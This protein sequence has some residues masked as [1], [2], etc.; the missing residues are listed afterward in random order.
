MVW[1]TGVPV[2][3]MAMAGAKRSA[4][5]SRPYR[6]C[7]VH[8]ASTAPGVETETAP[9]GAIWPFFA[10]ALWVSRLSD[11]GERPEPLRPASLLVLGSQTMAKQSP[12]TPQEIGSSRPRAALAATAASTAEPPALRISMA[13]S[14]ARGWAVA[15]APCTPHAAEREAKLAPAMRSPPWISGRARPRSVVSAP[16]T[17]GAPAVAAAAT[18]SEARKVRRRMAASGDGFQGAAT[19][20]RINAS[21]HRPRRQLVA[22]RIAEVEAPA[23]G[24]GEDRL[25]DRAARAA[26][27]GFHRLEIMGVEDDQR[28]FR[29]LRSD[30]GETAIDAFAFE[31]HIVRPVVGE[32][33]AERLA[34]EPLG[35]RK[36]AA[37]ELDIV[38]LA[39]LAH[40]RVS[41]RLFLLRS[42]PAATRN[43]AADAALRTET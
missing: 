14:V 16:V 15:A 31:G 35:G 3:A 11:R 39:V 18:G 21:R 37:R 41:W 20:G 26:H 12:P 17:D 30:R 6:W 22:G 13:V 40:G 1:G 9:K 4:H 34:V 28:L 2:S 43:Q 23:A 10:R 33:P 27:P 32:N 38:D 7:R 24:K 36:V 5:F 29:R 19:I 42:S 25:G 8:Q